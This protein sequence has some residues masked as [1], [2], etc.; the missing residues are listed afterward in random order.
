MGVRQLHIENLRIIEDVVIDT[1]EQ[2]TVID[3]ENA[4]GKTSSL[5]ALF[6]L[7]RGKS[8]RGSRN[9]SLIRHGSDFLRVTGV[10][11]QN[12]VRH[13]LGMELNESGLRGRKDGADIR[14]LS[15]LAR[16]L[17]VQAIHGES[18]RLILDGPDERR[19]FI[20]W[21]MFHVEHSYHDRW[22][23]YVRTLRQ[24][25]AAL[26]QRDRKLAAALEPQMVEYGQWLAQAQQDYVDRLQIAVT[27]LLPTLLQQESIRL[28]YRRGWDK[29]TALADKLAS[30][31]E[32]E[33]DLG[34]TV[35]GPHRADLVLMTSNGPAAEQLSRG[36]LK[37]LVTAL[38]IAQVQMLSEAGRI[39]PLLLFDDLPAELDEQRRQDIIDL[40]REARIQTVITGVDRGAIPVPADSKNTWF[41][42]EHGRYAKVV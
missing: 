34:Y 4:S 19:R 28:V 20:H 32:R 9:Q 12:G 25:N 26:R 27:A 3:G 17:P 42:V 7:A 6:F 16:V 39:S 13:R 33:L 18:H 35:P 21:G 31:R 37:W 1:A 11:E 22:R 10:V 29:D 5:E 41:H 8:F 14:A 24:R 15:E 30:S 38:L 40:L 23:Y 2:F 36:Q